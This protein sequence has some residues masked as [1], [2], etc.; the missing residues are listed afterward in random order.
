MA[1]RTSG[2]LGV[3]NSLG[4]RIDP[5]TES[6]LQKIAGLNIPAHDEII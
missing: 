3:E 6:T 1:D 2:S 5:A 4:I